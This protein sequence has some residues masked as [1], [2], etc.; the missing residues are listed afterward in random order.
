MIPLRIHSIARAVSGIA[1]LVLPAA[2]Q[3][4]NPADKQK[5]QQP[6]PEET[7]V[8]GQAVSDLRE[9]DRIGP[10]GQPEWTTH[11]R[12]AFT[13]IYVRPPG[14]F[15]F[16]YWLRPTIPRDGGHPTLPYSACR[17]APHTRAPPVSLICSIQRRRRS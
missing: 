2:A 12:F 8:T 7:V 15:G 3:I 4:V 1:V 17:L 5:G 9:E 16:E 13:R 11:R 6:L 10:Y 14:T